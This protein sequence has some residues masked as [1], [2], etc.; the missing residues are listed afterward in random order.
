MKN[1]NLLY[2]FLGKAVGLYLLWHLVYYY[3]I[4]PEGTVNHVLTY[5]VG[6]ISCVMLQLFGYN[7]FISPF[8]D[9]ITNLYVDNKH[10]VMIEH[11]CNGLVLMALFAGFVIA[12]PGPLK[13]KLWYVPLGIVA[14]YVI[15]SLRVVALAF[16]QMLS[17]GTFDFNHKYTFT[18]VVYGAI[19]FFWMLWANKLSGVGTQV[20]TKK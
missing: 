3:W 15:N 12:Y 4:E 11:G 1:S 16:N 5:A 14:I 7:S 2:Q 8:S 17:K 18:I 19:F 13:K 9:Q 20:A 10:L 6:Y